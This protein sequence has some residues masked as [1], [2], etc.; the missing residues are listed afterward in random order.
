MSPRVTR[1]QQPT[2]AL[3]NIRHCYSTDAC[4][5]DCVTLLVLAMQRSIH[6]PNAVRQRRSERLL[7]LYPFL[8]VYPRQCL[9][10]EV[11]SC[12]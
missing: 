2:V 1:F 8:S 11:H 6:M 12:G 4:I 5:G 10:R 7:R 3:P 9:Y